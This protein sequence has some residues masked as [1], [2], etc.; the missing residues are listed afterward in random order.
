MTQSEHSKISVTAKLVAYFRQ[1]SDIPFAEEVAEFIHAKEAFE[2]II[3]RS[4]LETNELLQ[5]APIFEARYKSIVRLLRQ[6]QCQQVLELASGF[7]LRGLAMSNSD[8]LNYIETDLAG[9]NEE[10]RK[11]I[12]QV[13]SAHNLKNTGIHHVAT[14]NALDLDELKPAMVPLKRGSKLAIVNEG[15]IHYFSAD[16]R[17]TLAKIIRSILEQFEGS[18]WITPDFSTKLDANNVPSAL[19]KLRDA[20]AGATD[21]ELYNSAFETDEQRDDFFRKLGFNFECHFQADLVEDIASVYKLK[22]RPEVMQRLK[23]WMRI[24]V[25]SLPG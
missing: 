4:D 13:R 1:F 25:L 22:I 11:L 3:E 9:V 6:H 10:K 24:W 23:R 16:E 2:G 20:I 18:I 21:R 14:A 17:E 7:S 12:E 8:G 15:L 5:Y 19:N